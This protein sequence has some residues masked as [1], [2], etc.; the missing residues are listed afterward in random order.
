MYNVISLGRTVPILFPGKQFPDKLFYDDFVSPPL[1]KDI[2]PFLLNNDRTQNSTNETCVGVFVHPN[3]PDNITLQ[4]IDCSL[5]S[6]V[7]CQMDINNYISESGLPT[8]PCIQPMQRRKRQSGIYLDF[9]NYTFWKLS[10]FFMF[11]I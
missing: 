5:K 7:I 8:V 2:P 11:Q 10:E 6:I 4:T 9:F 3:N 1:K